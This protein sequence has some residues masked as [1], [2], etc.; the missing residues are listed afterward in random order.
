MDDPE[1]S[2]AGIMENKHLHKFTIPK[3][4]RDA[5]KVSIIHCRSEKREYTEIL[6]TLDKGRL[7]MNSD[8]KSS[9]EFSEMKLVINNDLERNF[10]EKRNEMKELGRNIRELEEKY[11]F[12]MVPYESAVTISNHGLS[13][14]NIAT[15][16]LGCPHMG[17]YLFRH[18]DVAL[19]FTRQMDLTSNVVVVFKLKY[20]SF[21]GAW[22]AADVNRRTSTDLRRDPGLEEAL[23]QDKAPVLA[24]SS[25]QLRKCSGSHAMP[26]VQGIKENINIMHQD[27]QKI[28]ERTIAV[29]G[30]ARTLEDDL[31]PVQRDF[32]SIQATVNQQVMFG[33]VRKVHSVS[34]KK[35]ALDPTPHF[36][37]HVSKQTPIW[38]DP[39]DEQVK[40]SL[41]YIFE[42]D[43]NLK[44]LKAPRQCLP[45]ALVTATFLSQ[46]VSIPSVRLPSKTVSSGSEALANCTVAHRIGKGKDATVIFHSVRAPL[47]KP[48]LREISQNSSLQNDVQNLPVNMPRK[49]ENHVPTAVFQNPISLPSFSVPYNHFPITLESLISSFVVS[50]KYIKDPRLLKRCEQEVVKFS[51]QCPLGQQNQ[52]E[53][54]LETEL[55]S[56]KEKDPSK[57]NLGSLENSGSKTSLYLSFEEARFSDENYLLKEQEIMK[58]DEKEDIKTADQ[59][60]T[61]QQGQ[62]K[63]IFDNEVSSEERESWINNVNKTS[64]YLSFEKA[65]FSDDSHKA[66]EVMKTEKKQ[67]LFLTVNE[68]VE[69]TDGQSFKYLS[70]DEKLKL[71]GQ[72][73]GNGMSQTLH[74]N[75]LSATKCEEPVRLS[76]SIEKSYA[77]PKSVNE[78]K[79]PVK[80]N[81]KNNL[82]QKSSQLLSSGINRGQSE[83]SDGISPRQRQRDTLSKD[84]LIGSNNN[85][86]LSSEKLTEDEN[87]K[88]TTQQDTLKNHN[89]YVGDKNECSNGNISKLDT[90]MTHHTNKSIFQNVKTSLA[91]S[92]E[93]VEKSVLSETCI[94]NSD[95]KA[96]KNANQSSPHKHLPT[97]PSCPNTKSPKAADKCLTKK[98]EKKAQEQHLDKKEKVEYIKKVPTASHKIITK[99]EKHNAVSYF[100]NDL[101]AKNEFEKPKSFSGPIHKHKVC[102]DTIEKEPSSKS[103][104]LHPVLCATKKEVKNCDLDSVGSSQTEKTKTHNSLKETNTFVD[105]RCDLQCMKK[106]ESRIDWKGIFGIQREKAEEKAEFWKPSRTLRE[107]SGLRIFPDMEI[108]IRNS[109]Y[110]HVKQDVNSFVEVHSPIAVPEMINSLEKVVPSDLQKKCP[111][112]ETLTEK[113]SPTSQDFKAPDDNKPKQHHCVRMHET[114]HSDRKLITED[115]DKSERIDNNDNKLTC[116]KTSKITKKKL[117]STRRHAVVLKRSFRRMNKFSQS[118]KNIKAVLGLLSGEI[119]LCKSKR[120]SK[121]LDRAVLHLRKAHKRVQ[122]SL[123]L[124]AKPGRSSKFN[125]TLQAAGDCGQENH[126]NE[127]HNAFK[128]KRQNGKISYTKGKLSEN[129]KIEGRGKKLLQIPNSLK[130]AVSDKQQQKSSVEDRKCINL[131]T[132]VANGTPAIDSTLVAPSG[133]S[134]SPIKMSS[135]PLYSYCAEIATESSENSLDICI[136]NIENAVP[137]ISCSKSKTEKNKVSTKQSRKGKKDRKEIICTK[138]MLLQAKN[139]HQ[140]HTKIKTSR[141]KT[142]SACEQIQQIRKNNNRSTTE[143]NAKVSELLLGKL[144]KIL[145]DASDTQNLKSLQDCQSLCKGILPV[146]IKSFERK[147]KCTWREVIVDRKFLFSHHLKPGFK[148]TLQPHAVE[149]FLELQMIIE[150]SQFIDNRIRFI[151]GRPTFRSL[152]W[153]DTSLY[154]ELLSGETGFQQ[155]SHFYT[156][157]Q[158][159]LND[160]AVTTLDGLCSRLSEFLQEIDD[161]N[162]SYYVY[163]KYKRELKE[164]EDVLKHDCD[165][166]AFSLSIPF[167]CGA[168]LGDTVE[169]LVALQ[170]S[171]LDILSRFIQLPKV[172]PGKKEHALC[173]LEMISAKIDFLR[174]S[175]SLTMNLSLF[176]IQHLLFDAA[177]MTVFKG[178]KEIVKNKKFVF[179]K[180]IIGQINSNAL[181]KLYEVFCVP[182]EEAWATINIHALEKKNV[183]S[184]H[185]FHLSSHNDKFFVGKIIDQARHAEPWLLQQMIFECQKHLDSQIKNFQILQ[186]CDVEKALINDSNVKE[187][188]QSKDS[189]TILIKTEAVEAFIEL[190]MTFETL[191]FLNCVMASQKKQETKRGL[192]WY[193]TSLLSDLVQIEQK[194]ASFLAGKMNPNTIDAIESRIVDT[195]SELKVISNCSDSVNYAYAFQIMMRELSE[196]SELKK[197]FF[198]LNSTIYGYIHFSPCV[199]SLHYGSLSTDLDYNYNQFSDFL[200]IL[201]SSPK[202]DLGKMAHTMKIM[203]TIEL[204]KALNDQNNNSPFDLITCQILQN[205]MKSECMVNKIPDGGKTKLLTDQSPRKRKYMSPEAVSPKK[206]KVISPCGKSPGK[207]KKEKLVSHS[208]MKKHDMNISHRTESRSPVKKHCMKSTVKNV[209][210]FVSTSPKCR[211]K[212]IVSPVVISKN[213]QKN[214]RTNSPSKRSLSPNKVNMSCSPNI[215]QKSSVSTDNFCSNSKNDQNQT[216]KKFSESATATRS[217]IKISNELSGIPAG[218]MHD[219][220]LAEKE[221]IL[222][223]LSEKKD[224]TDL[225][226]CLSDTKPLEEKDFQETSAGKEKQ[227]TNPSLNGQQPQTKYDGWGKQPM[228]SV[229]SLYPQYPGSSNPWQHSSYL[230]YQLGAHNNSLSQAF[231]GLPY[232][233]QNTNH[234]NQASSFSSL[235]SYSANQPYSN[236]MIQPQGYPPSGPFGATVPY[237][238]NAP[239]STSNQNGVPITYPYASTVMSGWSW[240]KW[241]LKLVEIDVQGC[242]VIFLLLNFWHCSDYQLYVFSEK[243]MI[244][245]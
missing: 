150:T 127:N 184:P 39:F 95:I 14:G 182:G 123:Q 10:F 30:R 78:S 70:M 115:Q 66:K 37:S 218:K 64:L 19:N 196:L 26:R 147:Q 138:K 52:K 47:T 104:L 67:S 105:I 118:E 45:I 222:A 198:K 13:V 116:I 75:Q 230:W 9:W 146:F 205:R 11:C 80:I 20:V 183:N 124:V 223:K 158:E 148:S 122:K 17:A 240:M 244:N 54:V 92:K 120:I 188:T 61:E 68:S 220:T 113:T 18:V 119:P 221:T 44:P 133:N 50:S 51:D 237:N 107:P 144:S 60:L 62:F 34:S 74:D 31:C 197:M 32:G 154:S 243:S 156:A 204:A 174:T 167:S 173:L 12:L 162:S 175:V 83:D 128:T 117:C 106:L 130:A 235:A 176:G 132:P 159:K 42:Y 43:S 180:E 7:N 242:P 208:S 99:V 72:L 25:R 1:K 16:V 109:H 38:N 35:M 225:E 49:F 79:Y 8:L 170:K 71:S 82:L 241:L 145:H 199:V 231:P 245:S 114:V 187:R 77:L 129:V 85:E 27:V 157:F 56:L 81:D 4:K 97:F 203:K 137:L 164:C 40:H 28:R 191:H 135:T 22:L 211:E 238:Y 33:R 216:D 155:Q 207:E 89:F 195:K 214:T 140:C 178:K 171:T 217:N 227:D 58:M 136:A 152:L 206:E 108:T 169:D 228:T 84:V 36:D 186:E 224:V 202:K 76:S 6:D 111:V 3:I 46:K 200:E 110:V 219:E 102:N 86:H 193:D 112:S 101:D 212:D 232:D 194:L 160:S 181:S 100:T 41:I 229:N 179:S 90:A 131:K 185:S 153:Y 236:F 23:R 213:I 151:E 88:V 48:S 121:R 5:E 177:K 226:K 161:K 234:Y 210:A 2:S 57:E 125:E 209:K 149:S 166:S 63:C 168:H 21:G 96:K 143:K 69:D 73:C 233:A 55:S 103:S 142:N 24:L 29:E 192:L 139:Y 189:F 239:S 93:H 201:M 87:S 59:H 165:Y 134:P 215:T 65:H 172:E 98:S 126:D 53:F 163:L 91:S 141:K 94:S 15:K 190:A